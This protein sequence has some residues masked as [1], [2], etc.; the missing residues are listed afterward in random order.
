MNQYG[1]SDAVTK[2]IDKLQVEVS[3]LHDDLSAVTWLLYNV[4]VVEGFM[5]QTGL[6]WWWVHSLSKTTAKQYP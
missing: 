4:H 3:N 1:E 2:S 5:L 6:I